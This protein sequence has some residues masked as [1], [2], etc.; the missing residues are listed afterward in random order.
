MTVNHNNERL[1]S[2]LI[3]RVL[4]LGATGLLGNTLF[5]LLIRGNKYHPIGTIRKNESKF[6]FTKPHRENLVV[7]S[8]VNDEVELDKLFEKTNPDVV[9]N[10]ISLDGNNFKKKSTFD[11]MMIYSILPHRLSKLC[12]ASNSRLIHISSDG[13]FSGEKG[14]YQ[15]QDIPDS[16]ELYGLVKYLGELRESHT[17]TLRT[18]LIGHSLRENHGIL[19]WFLAQNDSCQ[20]FRNVIFSGLPTIELSIVIRDY[21]IAN[22]NLSGLYHVAAKPIS[23]YDLLNEIALVYKKDIKI[24][25]VSSPA[26]DRSLNPVHFYEVAGYAA[27]EWPDLV[28]FMYENKPKLIH[29]V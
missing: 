8:D 10:C 15:E 19:D 21:I 1:D 20:G 24:L 5:N 2:G 17:V 25:P 14:N 23:K 3:Q 29:Y 13:V 26:L 27:P 28:K 4:V 22:S 18:S 16:R 7:C 9:I 6:F 12:A 11:Y